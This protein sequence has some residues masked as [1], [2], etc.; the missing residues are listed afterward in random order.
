MKKGP[1]RVWQTYSLHIKQ[2]L[3]TCEECCR[4]PWVALVGDAEPDSVVTS[5]IADVSA[6]TQGWDAEENG[7]LIQELGREDEDGT[8]EQFAV[9]VTS[10]GSDW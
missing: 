3:S 9:A 6:I 2:P 7:V 1:I 10:C 5:T 8:L 4:G